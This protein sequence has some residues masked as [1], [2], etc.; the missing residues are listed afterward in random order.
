MKRMLGCAVAGLLSLALQGCSHLG[1]SKSEWTVLFDGKDTGAFNR[2]GN[3]NWQV[4][5]GTISADAGDGFLVTKET[6]RDFEVRVEFYA[7]ADTNSGVFLRCTDPTTLAS[8]TCYEVN[9]WDL[10]PVAKYG[11]GAIVDVAA[12]DPMPKAG[13]KW[14]TYDITAQGDHLV[15]VLNGVKT[16]DVH[17]SRRAEGHLGLQ[18][19]PGVD[20]T[21]KHVI[22]FRKVEIRRL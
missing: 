17:D 4:A 9:I 15:V 10:R 2:V 18:H 8:K 6:Y 21:G 19:A 5:D 3:A 11:T 20:K 14:N 22:R 1:A 7:E 12:V 16:A 13:G